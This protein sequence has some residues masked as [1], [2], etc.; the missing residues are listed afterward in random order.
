MERQLYIERILINETIGRGR[1]R[2]TY[3]DQIEHILTRFVIITIPLF[4][5]NYLKR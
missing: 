1:S 5:N 4:I 3:I 2:R